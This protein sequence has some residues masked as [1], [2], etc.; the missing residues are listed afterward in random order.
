MTT[1]ILINATQPEEVRVAITENGQLFDFDIE[2][3]HREQKKSNI[4][5]AV[6]T[7]LFGALIFKYLY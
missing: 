3:T 7:G 1:N 6:I 5:K 4:Y 2:S